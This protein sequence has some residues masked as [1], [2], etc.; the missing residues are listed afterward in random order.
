MKNFNKLLNNKYIL[1]LLFI[2][3]LV[4]LT[5]LVYSK[6]NYSILN[7]ALI[8]ILIY[9]FTKN[10][11]IVLGLTIFIINI[12][13]LAR[14]SNEGFTDPSNNDCSNFTNTVYKNLYSTDISGIPIQINEFKNIIKPFMQDTL[15]GNDTD[16][17]F[18]K[19]YKN[20]VESLDNKSQKWLSNN[21]VDLEEYKDT[22]Y[23]SV[24]TKM[25]S[26][27]VEPLENYNGDTI[28][29][30]DNDF[31]KLNAVMENVKK[32]NPE[33]D[34]IVNN[35]SGFDMNELNKLVNKLN[36]LVDNA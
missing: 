19:K 30:T 16:M 27:K 12:L 2:L 17:G 29:D 20:E 5:Y 24:N 13:I 32:S 8:A 4:N 33:M 10:M 35:I 28:K 11:I 3:T 6:D 34:Q 36:N 15:D 26:S 31:K 1:Y 21:I 14:K 9:L 18:Y 7:F 25:S 23:T 22:C